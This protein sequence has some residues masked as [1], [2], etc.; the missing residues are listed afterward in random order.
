MVKRQ[1]PK[2][3]EMA[4]LLA[5]P[6]RTGTRIEHRL[7]RDANIADLRRRARRRT[8]RA[9]F[10]Y[11]DGAADDE[12]SLARSRALFRSIEFVPHVLRDVSSC[13]PSTTVLGR[14]VDYPFGFAPTGMTRF[15]RHE[16]EPAV[17]CVAAEFDI[18][19][20]LSTVGTTTPE[21]L[22]A[23]VSDSDLWFQLY[24]WKE[25][26]VS[27]T[28]ID[29]VRRA[30]FRTLVF[31][32]DLPVGGA[33]L[34][35]V[36]NGLSFPPD[37]TLR[38][39]LD[40]ARHP[41][42][43]VNFLTTEPIS[44][45]SLTT[46]AGTLMDTTDKLFDPALTFDDISWLRAQWQGP[47]VVKGVQTVEDARRAVDHGADGVVISNHG[48]RQL[49]R[50]PVPLRLVR[51]TVDAIGNDA[52][53]YVDGGIMN[54]ADIVAAIALGARAAFVGRA[55]LY[56]LMAGGEPGVRR[57]ATILTDDIIRTMKLL[58]VASVDQLNPDHVR[59]PE[60]RT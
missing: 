11:V 45:A 51:P 39:V 48:G 31:T 7:S 20:V 23:S 36:R 43:W 8:P 26:T 18:P 32:V 22:A 16:G 56:G 29:A 60:A 41:S 58:G 52:E 17:A 30:G 57:A 53:V 44:F 12:V 33:R 34:R 5:P 2:W 3:R 54:G 24:V 49:D 55:Y 19:Y 37:L 21:A 13:D 25:R 6:P 35:D 9:P 15:M 47:I 14:R 42:W 27:E 40:G 59:L 4:P 50:S 28:L 46:T 10:D 1:W 38:T